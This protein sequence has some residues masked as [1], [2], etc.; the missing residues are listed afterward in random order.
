M[1]RKDVWIT[2]KFWP[3]GGGVRETLV[4]SL[5]KMGTSYVDLY[6]I[7]SPKY[8]PGDDVV[9]TWSEFEKVR[10][11]GLAR[12]VFDCY[13]SMYF[14]IVEQLLG[15]RSI[16]VSNFTL[17]DLRLLMKHAKIIPAVNQVSVTFVSITCDDK[18]KL[19]RYT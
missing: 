13:L 11:E 9:A 3:T 7:H 8:V 5:E 2:T 14:T 18:R 10:K 4:K 1:E 15:H 6:L 12:F 17:E 16:G 19:F